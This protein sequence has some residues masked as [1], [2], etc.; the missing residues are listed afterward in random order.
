MGTNEK[1]KEKKMKERRG[2]E[3]KK[4][5]KEKRKIKFFVHHGQTQ[6][7][8]FMGN[9]VFPESFL[10]IGHSTNECPKYNY[11]KN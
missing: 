9:E 8:N 7:D 11:K 4:G 10:D 5:E 3:R 1:V 2:R 6:L